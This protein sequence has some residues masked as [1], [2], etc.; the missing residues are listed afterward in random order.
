VVS[1]VWEMHD[2]GKESAM[3]RDGN[4]APG[5]PFWVTPDRYGAAEA[6]S[7]M[8][9]FAAPLLGG[10][11]LAAMVQ[12][13][14]FT[15]GEA[16]WPDVA[17]LLFL[18]AATLFIATV[19]AMFWAR[20]YQANPP[21]IMGWWPDAEDRHRLRMLRDE[22][23]RHAEGFRMWSNRARVAY[24]AAVLCLLAGLTVLAVP[25][26]SHGQAPARWAAVAIGVIA[27]FTEVVWTA[28][29]VNTG[30]WKWAARLLTPQRHRI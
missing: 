26:G 29:S 11:S 30:R 9:T 5:A 28:A 12:T 17:L 4:Q 20:E 8:G 27:F 2:D 13:L 23:A 19:Q 7:S 22:Q 3:P 18:L 10:F 6:L 1:E 21:E 15:S 16:R 24:S 14:T 25:A